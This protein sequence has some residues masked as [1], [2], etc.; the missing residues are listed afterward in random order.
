MCEGVVEES[1]RGETADEHDDDEDGDGV[2][3]CS[4]DGEHVEGDADGE[5]GDEGGEPEGTTATDV[6]PA[7]N[8]AAKT[9]A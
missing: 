9:E 7:D 6:N 8:E 2:C 3:W 1:A 5:K 4:D